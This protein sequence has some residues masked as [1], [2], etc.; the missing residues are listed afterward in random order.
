MDR[1]IQPG[2]LRQG[3]GWT[4]ADL[5]A[6][7]REVLER[8][9]YRWRL[10]RI[11]AGPSPNGDGFSLAESRLVQDLRNAFRHL[12]DGAEA[13]IRAW[14][15][16]WN[17][18][19]RRLFGQDFPSGERDMGAGS[20]GHGVMGVVLAV[21]LIA[22][23]AIMLRRRRRHVPTVSVAGSA[24]ESVDL[25]QEQVHAD[26][27]SPDEWLEMAR[28]LRDRGE[29]RPAMRAFFLSGLA[30]LGRRE[31]VR[32]APAKTNLDYA[33]ELARFQEA[34][35]ELVE[36]FRENSGIFDR[37]WYGNHP[38]SSDTLARVTDNLERMRT[39]APAV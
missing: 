12:V 9:E 6:A 37:V 16:L 4:P 22:I 25:L 24:A 38:L 30:F 5:D 29:W 31:L 17:R 26:R 13:L 33:R 11:Q 14:Q 3:G 10:P 2:H 20:L 18:W 34:C 1:T 32:L 35:P 8:R 15:R 21:A 23:F 28:H 7:A 36:A 27:L 39:H 19:V